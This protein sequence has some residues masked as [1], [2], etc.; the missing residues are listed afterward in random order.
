MAV[1]GNVVT[2]DRA[3]ADVTFVALLGSSGDNS[4]AMWRVAEA[5]PLSCM[6]TASMSSSWNKARTARHVN[7]DFLIPY[8]VTNTTTGVISPVARAECHMK[9]I[10]PTN[11]PQTLLSDMVYMSQ[12]FG[13]SPA[14]SFVVRDQIATGYAFT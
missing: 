14:T 8:A 13:I 5:V 7:L 1:I 10:L 3:N 2:K 6:K 4:P 11:A 9:F 12:T